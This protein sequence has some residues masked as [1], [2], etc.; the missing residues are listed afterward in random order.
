MPSWPLLVNAPAAIPG[1]DFFHP[2]LHCEVSHG[3]AS[4][5]LPPDGV[6]LLLSDKHIVACL[7]SIFSLILKNLGGIGYCP[8]FLHVFLPILPDSLSSLESYASDEADM[9]A[10]VVVRSWSWMQVQSLYL[11][12]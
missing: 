7:V 12:H 10:Q 11:S 4:S 2:L 1:K 3:V 6:N 8:F 5:N 9:K